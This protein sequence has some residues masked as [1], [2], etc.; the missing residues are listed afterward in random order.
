MAERI[1]DCTL[2]DGGYVNGWNFD[3]ALAKQIVLACAKA[4][5][6]IVEIGYLSKEPDAPLCRRCPPE[7]TQELKKIA[8]EIQLA[9]MLEANAIGPD[10]GMPDQTGISVLRFALNRDKV[11]T[12]LDKIAFYHA[13]GYETFLQLMGITAYSDTQLCAVLDAV[14]ASGAVDCISLGD[15]YGSLIPQRT[16]QL[17]DLVKAH[18][19]RKT[20]LHAHNNMQLGM[21]NVLAA[22]HAGADIVDGSIYGMGRGGGNVPTE[23]M[24]TYFEKQGNK[25][26]HALAL[27]ELID[28]QMLRMAREYS[29]GY[30]LAALISGVYECH[31]YYTERLIEKREYTI[32]QVL[33]TAQMVDQTAVVGFDP[34]LLSAIA[35]SGF[36]VRGLD[37]DRQAES[38]LAACKCPP[39]YTN[40]HSGR[41]F[42]VL[43]GGPSVMRQREIID[44]YILRT[45]PIILVANRADGLPPAHYHA[46]NNQRRFDQYG[47]TVSL[48]SQ[49]LLGPGINTQNIGRTYMRLECLNSSVTPLRI[50]NGAISTNCRSIAVLLGAVALVMG[51]ASIA[52]AGLD[53][54]HL[55]GQKLYYQEEES[56]LDEDLT[57]KHNKNQTYLNELIQQSDKMGVQISFLTDT[58]YLLRTNQLSGSPALPSQKENLPPQKLL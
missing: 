5:V 20:A 27:L 15:S 12:A 32:E 38:Y 26:F 13:Q 28:R 18:T 55:Q 19:S 16:E 53:G 2:R 35:E 34:Q 25:Q 46:F 50:Q 43:G 14:E 30:S 51:A 48:Q 24:V 22:L 11:I 58:T 41:A 1:L 40:A 49:L 7:F 10:Y 56:N 33:K 9:A 47:A 45:N 4:G 39:A 6:D 54:Y 8:P 44:A 57:E 37:Y 3:T 31:P 52:F 36:S 23:L 21:A 17:V 42:L 29:W